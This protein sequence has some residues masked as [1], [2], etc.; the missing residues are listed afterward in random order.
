MPRRGRR[1][2]VT[3]TP[4]QVPIVSPTS[5]RRDTFTP[6]SGAAA[7]G[8]LDQLAR[9]LGVFNRALAGLTDRVAGDIK[10][11]QQD[12]ANKDALALQN[13]DEDD[14]RTEAQ[15][16]ADGVLSA[17]E[18]SFYT[19]RR[20]QILG[21]TA[22][23][24]AISE[25]HARH[26]EELEE[27]TDLDEYDDLVSSFTKDYIRE[28]AGDDPSADFINSFLPVF[29]SYRAGARNN[30]VSALGEKIEADTEDQYGAGVAGRTRNLIED[31][32]LTS[33]QR[34]TALREMVDV[35]NELVNSPEFE[36]S[37]KAF[38]KTFVN[39]LIS[40][41]ETAGDADGLEEAFRNLRFGPKEQ[42]QDAPFL[43]D[44]PKLAKQMLTAQGR[45]LV[46]NN[47]LEKAR[48]KSED[49]AEEEEGKQILSDALI[50]ADDAED[51]R[52]ASLNLRPDIE[53]ARELNN[54][55]LVNN[56]INLQ[57]GFDSE[58]RTMPAA[59]FQR[60]ETNIFVA[61]VGTEGY[62]TLG[63][64]LRAFGAGDMSRKQFNSLKKDIIDRD[65]RGGNGIFADDPQ[66]LAA[67]KFVGKHFK[68][69]FGQFDTY[70]LGARAG[71]AQEVVE[72]Q[73]NEWLR[74]FPAKNLTDPNDPNSGREPTFDERIRMSN[75]VAIGAINGV[76]P[77]AATIL[78]VLK[79]NL[80]IPEGARWPD[81]VNGNTDLPVLSGGEERD[82]STTVAGEAPTTTDERGL[83]RLQS[84]IN[85]GAPFDTWPPSVRNVVP[86]E[87]FGA[88]YAKKYGL[89]PDQDPIQFWVQQER[90]R[91]QNLRTRD[92]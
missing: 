2:Q 88:N 92:Q 15:L 43:I 84:A 4:L 51:G 77:K 28:V 62:V 90:Q 87:I 34:I 85:F 23:Q 78:A 38:N 52:S 91:H 53:R 19:A 14:R 68:N 40:A 36:G 63:Q 5:R 45:I 20:E 18:G 57:N 55:I 27:I 16:R 71:L 69:Q 81:G 13:L 80:D 86:N 26:A 1:S 44:N 35:H 11:G 74:E 66:V 31:D 32:N 10:E 59:A 54:P 33:E 7:K 79:G 58:G 47:R 60:L 73:Y 82:G 76:H 21:D 70:E 67:Q 25:F 49:D 37:K 50:A 3:G 39:A 56:L 48:D 61:R 9:G 6:F 8:E 89:Q 72:Q 41:Y 75:F 65:T 12:A 42:G 46:H 29:Q 24:N 30:F 64:V 22:A 17:V 83:D